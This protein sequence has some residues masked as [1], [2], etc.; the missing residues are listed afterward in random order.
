MND[1]QQSQDEQS[2]QQ[3]N[4]VFDNINVEVVF[5]DEP[6]LTSHLSYEIQENPN[7]S[8]D[9]DY[10]ETQATK[11]QN[12]MFQG[13]SLTFKDSQ[14]QD[15]PSQDSTQPDETTSVEQTTSVQEDHQ[16]ITQKPSSTDEKAPKQPESG[17][18]I[19]PTIPSETSSTMTLSQYPEL[20][21]DHVTYTNT[22]YHTPVEDVSFALYT[23]KTY[24]I[25]AMPEQ[26][27]VLLSLIGNFR[28]TSSGQVLLKSRNIN[29]VEFAE[30]RAHHIAIVPQRYAVRQDLDAIH[31]LMH[32]M[33]ASSINFL[34]PKAT[35]A[36]ELLKT[37]GFTGSS[38]QTP[39][40][41]LTQLEQRQV[42]I[43]CALSHEPQILVLD[44]PVSDLQDADR[45]II[46]NL[47]RNLAT[48]GDETRT[49]VMLTTP[50]STVD[51]GDEVIRLDENVA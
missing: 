3:K 27:E 50:S 48:S 22:S 44:Q 49:V 30:L 10:G 51:F 47:L 34:K 11:V 5:D 21:F 41:E 26:C 38:T 8:A 36:E 14:D 16:P 2:E 9:G 37:V 39:V 45:D 43:A 40:S 31:A 29:E 20:R 42:E 28:R 12:A 7:D 24:Q 15:K 17:A 23:G 18:T 33:D 13:M 25:V 6:L 19:L 1:E 46:L 4:D 32:V 35:L